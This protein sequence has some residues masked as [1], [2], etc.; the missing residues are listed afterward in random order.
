MSRRRP[1]YAAAHTAWVEKLNAPPPPP[2]PPRFAC[3]CGKG[4]DYQGSLNLHQRH[5]RVFREAMNGEHAQ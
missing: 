4:F 3:P 5:C 2:P 1:I